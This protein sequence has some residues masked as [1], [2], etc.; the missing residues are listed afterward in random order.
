M[1]MGYDHMKSSALLVTMEML[2]KTTVRSHWDV[3]V[4]GIVEDEMQRDLNALL[5]TMVQLLW[6]VVQWFLTELNI[7]LPFDPAIFLGCGWKCM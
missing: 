5:L 4:S 2:I 1:N 3:C 6:T 7:C